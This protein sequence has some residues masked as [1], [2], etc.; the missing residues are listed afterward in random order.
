MP[1]TAQQPIPEDVRELQTLVNEYRREMQR[2]K[3]RIAELNNQGH[4]EPSDD[5]EAG[6]ETKK[7]TS[8]ITVAKARRQIRK[9]TTLY[10]LWPRFIDSMF[11]TAIDPDYNPLER[12]KDKNTKVQGQLSDWH[13]MFPREL[14]HLVKEDWWVAVFKAEASQQ[15]SNL[16]SRVRR[17]AGTAI[18]GCSEDDL[19]SPEIRRQKFGELIG[20]PA[21]ESGKGNPYNVPILH[22]P[23][24]GKFDIHSVF[25]NRSLMKTLN[26]ILRGAQSI[27]TVDGRLSTSPGTDTVCAKW[28]VTHTTPGA[29]AMAAVLTRWAA[30]P[31]V[32]FHEV[33]RESQINWQAHYETYLKY[34]TDGLLKKKT[35]V[36]KIFRIWDQTLFPNSTSGYWGTGTVSQDAIS[37]A[38]ALL[39][40]DDDEVDEM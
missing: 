5:S 26:A 10:V 37:E 2:L 16:S 36:V 9:F 18:F 28:N 13:D 22:E 24:N 35:S 25:L 11:T 39:N 32:E 19:K 15:R 21:D 8:S 7:S 38:F 12:F 1:E 3:E 23:Y 20:L 29:I 33:G 6:A 17:Q 34:L 27:K 14:A 40:E 4:S 31:D 30:S